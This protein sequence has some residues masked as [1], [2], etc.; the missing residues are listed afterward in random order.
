[1]N[2]AVV[3]VREGVSRWLAEKVHGGELQDGIEELAGFLGVGSGDV[4]AI[5]M[6]IIRN[7]E[8][9]NGGWPS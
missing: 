2:E 9:P 5:V 8:K 7:G 6:D 1:M 3:N 4:Q